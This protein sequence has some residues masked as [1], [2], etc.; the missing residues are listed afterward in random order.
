MPHHGEISVEGQIIINIIIFATFSAF[1]VTA[2]MVSLASCIHARHRAAGA[3]KTCALPSG[4]GAQHP[5]QAHVVS[6]W[7]DHRNNLRQQ[8][9][10][11]LYRYA[12]P[13]DHSVISLHLYLDRFDPDL[14]TLHQGDKQALEHNLDEV[15]ARDKAA[16][17]IQA[18]HR[19]WLVRRCHN[20][21]RN[22][23]A[24]T[25]QAAHRG[26]LARRAKRGD[27]QRKLNLSNRRTEAYRAPTRHHGLARVRSWRR[28][29]FGGQARTH[30]ASLDDGRNDLAS[31][32]EIALT[33]KVLVI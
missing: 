19:G 33:I 1:F 5:G 7:S 28:L 14:N 24:T 18:V 31:F 13:N 25:I 16:V 21:A 29:C 22:T 15:L 3:R 10:D 2:A 4:P 9:V 12:R 32:E 27:H 6:D 20:A 23:A 30:V 17:N 8:R 26:F 11:R